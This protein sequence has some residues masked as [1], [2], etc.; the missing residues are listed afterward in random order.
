MVS[1]PLLPELCMFL[2]VCFLTPCTLILG[3][4]TS[5][6]LIVEDVR[7]GK[8]VG[9]PHASASVACFSKCVSLVFHTSPAS[10]VGVAQR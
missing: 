9:V 1:M 5:V 8:I 6:R 3:V 7:T 2:D 10:C 4:C